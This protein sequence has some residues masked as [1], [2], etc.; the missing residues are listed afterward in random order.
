MPDARPA[1]DSTATA[2]PRPMNFFTVSGLAATRRS[3][4]A[5]SPR[6]AI[7]TGFVMGILV[8]EEEEHAEQHEHDEPRAVLH[9]RKKTRVG[10][11]VI[12]H[13]LVGVR[14]VLRHLKRPPIR[15][16]FRPFIPTHSQL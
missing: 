14:A 5:V 9:H 8:V 3:K 15:T 13:R 6:T 7:R 4:S 16:Q 10:L 1:P 2:A 11:C 12:L